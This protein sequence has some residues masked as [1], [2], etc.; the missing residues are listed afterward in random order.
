MLGA[1]SNVSKMSQLST[2]TLQRTL[3]RSVS[4]SGI[5]LHSGKKVR[6]RLKPAPVNHGIRFKRLD[7][8]GLEVSATAERVAGMNYA[9]ELKDIR[10]M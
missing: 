4:C 7:L 5:G 3:K 2:M 9:T 8:D 6:L 1:G 10:F